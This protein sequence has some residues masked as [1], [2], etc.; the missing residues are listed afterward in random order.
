MAPAPLGGGHQPAAF[1]L[2][3]VFADTPFLVGRAPRRGIDPLPGLGTNR[4]VPFL[5]LGM[6]FAPQQIRGTGPCRAL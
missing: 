2:G 1:L 3:Q 4:I 6:K 5:V